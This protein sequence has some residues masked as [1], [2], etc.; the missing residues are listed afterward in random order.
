MKPRGPGHST[1]VL[2]TCEHAASPKAQGD[3][4]QQVLHVGAGQAGQ[5]LQ[6]WSREAQHLL[7]GSQ[8]G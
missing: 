3:S 4:P 1:A 6:V 8:F 2:P 7:R 5:P